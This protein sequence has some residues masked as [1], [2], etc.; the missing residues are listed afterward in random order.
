MTF[1][2]PPDA[3]RPLLEADL[4]PVQGTRFQPTGFPDLG[5]AT[6]RLADTT[7]MLLVESAQS[8]ANRLEA[9]CWDEAEGR[10]V[11]PLHGLPYVE[12]V[13]DGKVITNSLLEAHRLNSAYIERSDV[14]TALAHD[15]DYKKDE[16]LDR[17]RFV[18]ALCKYDPHT[19]LHGVFL[20]SI[21]G[22]LRLPRAL[23]GFIEARE[24]RV[25][26][27]GGV[28]NDRVMAGKDEAAGTTA[29][30]GF[31]NVPFHRD[32]YT[33]AS[34]T[35]YFNLD[36]D[37]L[38]SYRLGVDLE[39]CLYALALFKVQRFLARGLRLRTACDLEAGELRVT[40]PAGLSLP[41]LAAVTDA[42]PGLITAAARTGIFADPPISRAV[43]QAPRRG[44]A[45][46]ADSEAA[47]DD[48]P[49][50]TGKKPGSRKKAGQ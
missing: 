27:S 8:V 49:A 48:E 39:Q 47:S 21:A 40:R 33:A 31:G 19:L 46:D 13:R 35:A 16:P 34:I 18:R 38:R 2:K 7:E 24:V 29:K 32:E 50:P 1:P 41:S 14:A 17:L 43:F 42:L 5:A 45:K 30:E 26:S 20:E 12:V 44:K 23:G 11:A 4:R 9:T 22:V 36:L 3:P 10:L 15:I 37:Q 25:V 6:Y 28:K